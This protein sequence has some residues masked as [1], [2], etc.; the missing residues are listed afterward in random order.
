ME[1]WAEIRRLH[2]S[3][4]VPIKEIA[5]R[6]GIARNTVRSALASDAPP[7]YRRAVKSP[8]SAGSARTARTMPPSP[9]S[10]LPRPTCRPSWCC[11]GFKEHTDLAVLARDITCAR[12]HALPALYPRAVKRLP[13]LANK[14]YEGPRN[15]DRAFGQGRRPGSEDGTLQRTGHHG[16]GRRGERQRDPQHSWRALSH[17]ILDPGRLTAIIAAALVLTHL[18]H[19]AAT[20]RKDPHCVTTNRSMCHYLECGLM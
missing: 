12:V 18:E 17:V 16:A 4:E 15:R 19:P 7:A 2:R 8:L 14:G 9:A 13:T 1:D 3:E 20:R 11:A 5:R 6:L 10:V